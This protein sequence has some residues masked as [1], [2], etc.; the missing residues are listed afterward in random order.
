MKIKQREM[1]TFSSLREDSISR[2]K[3][4]E[5]RGKHERFS[6]LQLGCICKKYNIEYRQESVFKRVIM[7]AD[8]MV[9]KTKNLRV[10]SV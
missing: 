9:G 1:A 5:R 10:D 7:T 4:E 2:L 6:V 8:L 3:K